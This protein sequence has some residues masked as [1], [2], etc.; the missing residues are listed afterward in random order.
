MELCVNTQFDPVLRGISH[1]FNIW[2]ESCDFG[3]MAAHSE[4]ESCGPKLGEVD[5]KHRFHLFPQV[6]S[7]GQQNLIALHKAFSYVCFK[8]MLFLR[9]T[10]EIL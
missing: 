4:M 9:T 7:P 5:P 8:T 6:E 3:M 1:H 2:G 10:L